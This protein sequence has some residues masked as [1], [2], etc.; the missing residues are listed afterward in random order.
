MIKEKIHHLRRKLFIQ[1]T[2][3]PAAICMAVFLC[4]SLTTWTHQK[5]MLT[6]SKW[7]EYSQDLIFNIISLD[8]QE[9]ASKYHVSLNLF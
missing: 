5:L 9:T 1:T 3:P 8:Q 2:F 6:P 4:P 7:K